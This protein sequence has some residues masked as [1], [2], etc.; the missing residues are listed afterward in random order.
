MPRKP[1]KPAEP[2]E[3][4]LNRPMP[5]PRS[6]VDF[7]A[8]PEVF[9][10]LQDTI[11]NPLHPIYNPDHQ[12]LDCLDMPRLSFLWA[13]T[14]ATQK[15]KRV[16]G[17][18]E[19]VAFRTGGWQ[20]SRQESQMVSWFGRVPQYLITLDAE[21]CR[22]CSDVDFCMLVEHELYHI[23]QA[24]DEFGMPKFN[25]MTGEPSLM[26]ASHDVEEFVGV[27]RRYGMSDD[28]RKMVEVANRL[29]EVSRANIAHACGTCLLRL[30]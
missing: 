18:C 13:D 4:S 2:V 11:L 23:A 20:K 26:I 10:W 5:P 28:V 22:N 6:D 29:P 30:A 19:K 24:K 25:Q 15:A 14:E 21:Y 8:A 9:I 12:H 3:S 27:V 17:T 16:L 1:K 7:I